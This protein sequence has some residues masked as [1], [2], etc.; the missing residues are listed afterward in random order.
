MRLPS[1]STL[2]SRALA[3]LAAGALFACG[4]GSPTAPDNLPA[5]PVLVSPVGGTQ[6]STDT[7]TFTVQNARGFDSGQADY[8]F[9]VAIL[10]NDREIATATVSAGRGTTSATF[11]APLLR[12]ATLAW[13]VV[14]HNATGEVSSG[15]GT[16]RLPAVE[17]GLTSDPY[18]K[19][20]V[21]WWVPACSLA[22]NHYND[23]LEVLGPPNGGGKGPDSFFGFISLG[24]GGHVTVDMEGCAVDAPG[25][26]IRVYQT[27]SNEPV[28]LYASGAP[29]GPYVLVDYRKL[30]G[31]KTPGISSNH[32]DFD[33]AS[34][35]LEEARYLRIEDGELYPCP[36]DTVT[37]G[38]DIDAVELLHRKP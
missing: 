5:Q 4:G 17:C 19:S 3:L 15:T 23:P 30:C 18:A 11:A 33:L 35:G 21:E 20:V 14:G 22:Q 12:G 9:R 26:D 36:G 28:T 38:T 16:F 2:R 29:G 7:P 27:V 13:K 24:D 10:A 32:C 31:V 8:R 34:A 37:E 6:V 25:D 1:P